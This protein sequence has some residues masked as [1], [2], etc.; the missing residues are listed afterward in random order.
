MRAARPAFTAVRP[1]ISLAALSLAVGALLGCGSTMG[2]PLRMQT[3]G[4]PAGLDAGQVETGAAG[5]GRL[6]EPGF[7]RPGGGPLLAVG[8]TD[9][10]ALEGAYDW[11]HDLYAS[12][13]GAIRI[14]LPKSK[15]FRAHSVDFALGGGGGRGGILCDNE[16]HGH[17]YEGDPQVDAVGLGNLTSD[18]EC[19][20][21][22]WWDWR[23]WFARSYGGGFL[24]IGFAGRSHSRVKPY[25]RLRVQ[26]T[27][28]EN[29]PLTAWY[30]LGGGIQAEFAG[31]VQLHL[32]LGL[33][34][35]HNRFD[36]PFDQ[37][38]RDAGGLNLV[39]LYLDN[40]LDIYVEAGLTVKFDLVPA[41][42]RRG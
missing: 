28:A 10:L 36:H 7:L 34:A 25:G 39:L 18:F 8:V 33:S 15:L 11:S 26:L 13:S 9:W 17:D 4:A 32:G 14:T 16:S 23:S 40:N 22:R 37:L 31:A 35:W 29:I 2:P 5:H 3:F 38:D 24:D 12:G 1:P 20:G 42:R 6:V 30:A 19:P 21:D 27:K 41:R